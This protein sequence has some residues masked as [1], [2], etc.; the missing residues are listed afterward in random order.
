MQRK[1]QYV[2]M[3]AGLTLFVLLGALTFILSPAQAS[4]S[5]EATANEPLTE[6]EV[7]LNE[8]RPS[9]TTVALSEERPS[10]TVETIVE[11]KDF[12]A[13]WGTAENPETDVAKIIAEVES[14][15]TIHKSNILEKPGWFYQRYEGVVPRQYLSNTGEIDGIPVTELYPDDA[16]MCRV[17]FF[18]DK[19]G[20]FNENVGYTVDQKGTMGTQWATTGGKMI[21]LSLAGAT[22]NAV[23]EISGSQPF[24]FDGNMLMYLEAV[25]GDPLSS[26]RAWREGGAYT[27][28]LDIVYEEPVVVANMDD[29]TVVGERTKYLFDL[30]TGA[31][32]Q[33]EISYQDVDGAFLLFERVTYLEQTP[34][35]ALPQEA[36]QILSE[37]A[38]LVKEAK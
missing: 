6:T 18:I 31:I 37:A 8:E 34:V 23:N 2:L 35:D 4:H 16:L 20:Q 3:G 33:A 9:T 15:V 32:Q 28:V 22:P 1:F 30:T 21:N 5:F 24:P 17:W 12:S 38:E 29:V 13:S 11:E 7:A 26:A 27:I 19:D 14:L 25:Q 36:R 10:E